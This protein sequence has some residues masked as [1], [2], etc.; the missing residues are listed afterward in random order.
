MTIVHVL[1]CVRTT[2]PQ[3][4]KQATK[5]NASHSR[6]NYYTRRYP[7]TARTC[8]GTFYMYMVQDKTEVRHVLT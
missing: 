7:Y 2:K 8:A 4:R 5:G 6:D 1:L 3:W